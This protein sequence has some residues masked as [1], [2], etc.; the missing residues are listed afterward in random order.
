MKLEE[1][2]R[3][4]LQ[5]L[6]RV[7]KKE[8]HYLQETDARLFAGALSAK[9]L[10]AITQDPL[11]A[12]RLDAFVSRFGLQDTL[13]DK[14]LPT[15]LDALAEPKASAI[16]NLDRAEKLGWLEST[17][18]WLEMR[19]LRNQMVHEYI[20]DLVILSNAL[21]VGHEFVVTLVDTAERFVV[22]AQRRIAISLS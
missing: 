6:C 14:F 9:S 10:E 19:K 17:D 7:V 3:L 16:E 22:Q 12:E 8:S 21:K 20:E 5:F 18:D 2:L 11:L 4:R 13:A 1:G 15:L